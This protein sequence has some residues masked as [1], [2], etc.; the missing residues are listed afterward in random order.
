MEGAH[1]A[2]DMLNFS[3]VDVHLSGIYEQKMDPKTESYC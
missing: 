1:T 3:P 2:S